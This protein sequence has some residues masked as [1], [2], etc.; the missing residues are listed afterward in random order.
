MYN[1]CVGDLR[2]SLKEYTDCEVKA[3][4]DYTKVAEYFKE[5]TDKSEVAWSKAGAIYLMLSSVKLGESTFADIVTGSKY[6]FSKADDRMELYPVIDAMSQGQRSLLSY[7]DLGEM[8]MTGNYGDDNW[9]E[10]NESA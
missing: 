3:D 5:N 6:D 7:V 8:I 9:K 1:V 2:E 4:S 10:L